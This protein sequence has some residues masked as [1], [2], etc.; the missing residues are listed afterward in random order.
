MLPELFPGYV[1][2]R[3]TCRQHQSI[4]QNHDVRESTR[5]MTL[6]FQEMNGQQ[7]DV[8]R[9]TRKKRTERHTKKCSIGSF[10]WIPILTSQLGNDIWKTI[11]EK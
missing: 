3:G 8:E 7:G 10:I 6:L 4:R 2:E 5:K 9:I 1:W 11:G